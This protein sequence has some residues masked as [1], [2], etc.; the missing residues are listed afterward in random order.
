MAL[1]W[2]LHEHGKL[3]A[4]FVAR[5]EAEMFLSRNEAIHQ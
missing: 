4:A 3:V 5:D 2:E 1:D